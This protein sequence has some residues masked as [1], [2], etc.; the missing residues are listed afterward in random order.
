MI[1]KRHEDRP[2]SECVYH[3]IAHIMDLSR[4]QQLLEENNSIPIRLVDDIRALLNDNL[5]YLRDIDYEQSTETNRLADFI[6]KLALRHFSN[7]NS[8][9]A[10]RC[11]DQAIK[12]D[13]LDYRCYFDKGCLLA[14]MGEHEKAIV[15]YK[16]ITSLFETFGG[17]N[18]KNSYS[19]ASARYN[20]AFSNGELARWQDASDQY[21]AALIQDHRKDYSSFGLL[22]GVQEYEDRILLAKFINET[23]RMNLRAPNA[24]QGGC[25]SVLI[26]GATAMKI[27]VGNEPNVVEQELHH[28]KELKMQENIIQC[29]GSFLNRAKMILC[30]NL[31]KVDTTLGKLIKQDL[32]KVE[33]IPTIMRGL[34]RGLSQM[35]ERKKP[36]IHCD[37]KPSNIGIVRP[38]T[39]TMAVKIIDFGGAVNEGEMPKVG[40]PGWTCPELHTCMASKKLDLFA[41]G[42][43]L[44]HC[45]LNCKGMRSKNGAEGNKLQ[46]IVQ[47]AC[48]EH[49]YKSSSDML[50]DFEELWPLS[51]DIEYDSVV[52]DT[53]TEKQELRQVKVKLSVGSLLGT[54]NN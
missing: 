39:S 48:L 47:K 35:H 50:N 38:S 45:L 34:L 37:I 54:E 23:F 33:M 51:G 41:A 18:N 32:L 43:V 4:V 20:I 36:I 40:T 13:P 5:E 42:L 17:L 52:V 1:N 21:M 53:S 26:G 9:Q 30:L 49:G 3:E 6:Y 31:E 11:F 27:V 44:Q 19:V 28:L 2:D 8:Y 15:C 22:F 29:N 46:L 12:V 10:I 14:E 24:E 16:W 7:G 25:G